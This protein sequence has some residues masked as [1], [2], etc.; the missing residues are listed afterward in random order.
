M[1]ITT[2]IITLTTILFIAFRNY[3]LYFTLKL[4]FIAYYIIN[5][6][7]RENS[8]LNKLNDLI[9]NILNII[10]TMSVN[11]NNS[12]FKFQK[13]EY[14]TNEDYPTKRSGHRAVFNES[15]DSFYIWGGYCPVINNS[16]R[17]SPLFPEVCDSVLTS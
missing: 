9:K 7:F 16:Q 4:V 11:D 17:T 13:F 15:D 10:R 2:I 3:L 8:F 1:L 12:L 6:L 14:V 5:D